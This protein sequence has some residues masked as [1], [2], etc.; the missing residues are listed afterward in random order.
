MK[1]NVLKIL[2]V[3][4]VVFLAS[5]IYFYLNIWI[6][7]RKMIN[8]EWLESKPSPEEQRK[9]AY[10]VL[11][12]PFGNHHDAILILIDSGNK[13]SIPYILSVLKT[14][15]NKEEVICTYQH[16]IDALKKITGKNFKNGYKGWVKG[17]KE[18]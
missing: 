12:F 15:E 16:C 14:F 9:V 8:M 10:Q 4:F 11:N 13:E 6:P 5:S 2:S 3:L 7:N 17:L 1:K 18:K